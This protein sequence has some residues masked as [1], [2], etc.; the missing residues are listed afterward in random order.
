MEV[1]EVM[2]DKELPVPELNPVA[3]KMFPVALDRI[4]AGRCP[5]CNAEINGVDDF[6][7]EASNREYEI[8]G[9]CSACQDKIFE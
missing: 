7:D 5:L 3:K 9:M 8:S 1:V 4:N 6:K 2:T